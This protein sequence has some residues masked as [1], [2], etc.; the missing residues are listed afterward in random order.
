M[1]F[2]VL[3]NRHL[4][5]LHV[6]THSFPTRRSSDLDLLRGGHEVG[7]RRHVMHQ[8]IGSRPASPSAVFARLNGRVP[9]NPLWAD[10]GDGWGDSMTTCLVVSIWGAFRRAD[11]PQSMKTTRPNLAQTP[12]M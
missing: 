9:K 8:S 2:C 11:A 4:L 7:E 10:S 1:I 6:L 3:K 5:D 12:S